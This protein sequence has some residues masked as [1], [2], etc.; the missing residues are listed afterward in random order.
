MRDSIADLSPD[1]FRAAGKTLVDRIADFLATIRDQPVAPDTTPAAVRARVG[2]D[3]PVPR[4]GVPA[5]DVLERAA[6]VL[7][8]G[9][10]TER[11]SSLLRLHHVVSRAH[12]RVG[13]HARGALNS[14]C[15]A[16]G[17]SPIATEIERQSVRWIAELIGYSD[18]RRAG[19]LSAAE[20]SRTWCVSLPRCRAQA[21]LG[22]SVRRGGRRSS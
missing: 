7:L 5:G 9:L 20:T 12:R 16:W 13:G 4:L 8:S 22:R 10:D 3:T 15:G 1:D 2:A 17:L 18:R 14:N 6:D 19:C 11:T 21:E